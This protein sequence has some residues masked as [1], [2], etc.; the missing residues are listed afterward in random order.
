MTWVGILLSARFC[1]PMVETQENVPLYSRQKHP[2]IDGIPL[3][4]AQLMEDP[5]S[6]G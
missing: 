5:L 6:V 3:V 4:F 2:D 1:G